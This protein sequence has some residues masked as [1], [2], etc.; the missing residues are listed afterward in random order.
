MG[1]KAPKYLK[2]LT[3]ISRAS[4]SNIA[5]RCKGINH[6]RNFIQRTLY[7]FRFRTTFRTNFFTCFK[8][9]R[10]RGR[11]LQLY[12]SSLPSCVFPD[13]DV[14]HYPFRTLGID[15]IKPFEARCGKTKHQ[16][17]VCLHLH[18]SCEHSSPFRRSIFL[19]SRLV[20]VPHSSFCCPS[21][22]S[23]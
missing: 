22:S 12:I 13:A 7:I 8:C 4:S 5:S 1:Y 19:E 20:H 23:E 6:V 10:L 3:I 11:R 17:T 21:R 9:C 2:K 16:K 18:L 15:F 14:N